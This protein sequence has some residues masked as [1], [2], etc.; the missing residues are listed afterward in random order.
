MRRLSPVCLCIGLFFSGAAIAHAQEQQFE[1]GVRARDEER[2]RDVIAQMAAAIEADGKE[3][4][5]KIGRNLGGLF[6]GGTE[7]LPYFFLGEA[8][9]RLNECAPAIEAWSRSEQ[10]GVVQRNANYYRILTS[11][12]ESCQNRGILLPGNFETALGTTQKYYEEANNLSGRLAARS[13]ANPALWRTDMREAF[14]RAGAD[15]RE[16][17]A[18]LT[19]GAKTRLLTDFNESRAAADRARRVLV[20]LDSSLNAAIET[21]R[22]I[23]QQAAEIEQLLASADG[24]DRNIES[25]KSLWSPSHA[26]GIQA[27][28]DA[29]SRG[30]DR[31]AAASRGSNAGLLP[32]AR[33]LALDA[34]ARLKQVLDDLVRIERLALERTLSELL[35]AAQEVFSF[36]EG[37][38]TTLDDLVREKPDLLKP[39]MAEERASIERQVTAALRRLENARKTENLSGIREATRLASEARDKLNLLITTFGPL[40]LTQR[41]VHPVLQEGARLFFR[42]EYAPALSALEAADAFGPEVPLQPHVHL[43]RAA[44]L[45]ALFVRSG[46]SDLSLRDRAVEEIAR[47]R[48]LNPEMVPDDRFSP[49]FVAFFQSSRTDAPVQRAA[50]Q[51]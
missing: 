15:L 5:R 51:P 19:T 10:Q 39:E 9:F 40:T 12:K 17:Y 30:R 7:Y 27:G 42:G 14:E 11:G 13:Q 8:Y 35:V 31:L 3:S 48:A 25:K 18:K 44:A 37:G 43:I 16:S 20:D 47:C 36:V 45:H 23:Q 28:R 32:E 6:G 26:A 21:N 29:L 22:S 24:I 38:F 33:D 49:G 4:E 41:G 34:S 50:S 2:W 1:R 46:E